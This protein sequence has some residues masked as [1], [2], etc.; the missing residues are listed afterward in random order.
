[1]ME[2]KT[3]AEA[4]SEDKDAKTEQTGPSAALTST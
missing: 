3:K 2:K 1:M 4:S